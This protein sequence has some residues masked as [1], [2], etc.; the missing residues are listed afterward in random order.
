LCKKLN[1]IF[2]VDP[3]VVS[4]IVMS[5]DEQTGRPTNLLVHQKPVE[6]FSMQFSPRNIQ[7]R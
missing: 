4:M 6:K 2:L 1:D 7:Y 5:R 3:F